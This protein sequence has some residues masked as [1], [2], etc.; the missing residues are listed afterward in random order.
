MNIYTSVLDD[1][2]IRVRPGTGKRLLL[3][4]H[5]LS[6]DENSMMAFADSLPEDYWIVSPRAPYPAALRGYSWRESAVIGSWPAIE[7]FEPSVMKLMKFI[8]SWA[9]QNNLD[10]TTFDVAGFSQGGALAFTLFMMF[11]GFIN[12][13]GIL[14]GFAPD[15]SE[16][17]V[18]VGLF[19]GKKIFVAHGLIDEIV[20][21]S[22]A[23]SMVQYLL[24]AG[25]EVEFCQ[26]Q[27]GH[28]LGA[29]CLRAFGKYLQI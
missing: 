6:G 11:P 27:I 16:D 7:L 18:K 17:F 12:K 28:K 21:F 13:L 23:E 4:L 1:W 9:I 20:P 26:V 10:L 14:A 3:L 22:K 8:R 19:D 24:L 15:G 25:A 2:I 29:D 5:G